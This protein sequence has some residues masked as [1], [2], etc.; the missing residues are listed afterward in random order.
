MVRS[1][2]RDTAYL[3]GANG[4]A[5]WVGA[6]VVMPAANTEA[7]NE[8]PKKTNNRVTSDA[9]RRWY[10]TKPA[11]PREADDRGCPKTSRGCRCCLIRPGSTQWRAFG[12]IQI[13]FPTFPRCESGK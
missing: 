13:Q 4:Q 3:I 2:R 8:H 7:V 6:E 11:G 5:R 10:G 1:N 9:M 12:I